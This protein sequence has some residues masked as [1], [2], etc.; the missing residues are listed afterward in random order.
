[1]IPCP[2]FWIVWEQGGVLAVDVGDIG[3]DSATLS[4][5]VVSVHQR[6][7]GMLRVQ[8]EITTKCL[9]RIK[10][11]NFIKLREFL[12]KNE[13]SSPNEKIIDKGLLTKRNV[14]KGRFYNDKLMRF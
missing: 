14:N 3:R 5:N 1:M 8:L 7:Y 13:S 4:Q 12:M 11:P 9:A 2:D 6:G 10:D